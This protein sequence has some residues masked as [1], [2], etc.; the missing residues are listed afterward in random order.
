MTL[1]AASSHE[2]GMRRAA[3]LALVLGAVAIATVAAIA[4]GGGPIVAAAPVLAATTAYA[5]A[6]SPLRATVLP[7]LFV[8]LAVDDHRNAGGLWHT[9]WAPVGDLLRANLDSIIPAA[10]GLKLNGVEVVAIALLGLAAWRR[11]RADRIDQR[12][13]VPAAPVAFELA[14]LAVAAIV[15][16]TV[17]GL[18]RGGSLDTAIWQTRPILDTIAL[19]ALFA[20]ALRGPADH[21]AIGKM[22]VLAATMRALVATW[23][24]YAVA[25]TVPTHV[26]YTTDHG[27]SVLFALACAVLLTHLLE[28][29]DRRSLLHAA[30]FLPPILIGMHANAR[31]VAAVQ[32]AFVLAAVFLVGH[33]RT[34]RR[35]VARR[36][37]LAAPL[38]VLYAVAGWSSESRVFAPVH[39]VR[40]IVQNDADRSTWARHVESWNLAVSLRDR[41]LAG[42]GFGHEWDEVF[43]G[44]QIVSIFPQYR[45]APH[46]QI[47]GLL[48]FA[49]VAAF[50][51]IWG[52]LVLTVYLALR[53]YRLASA[54]ED[55]AAALCCAG[56]VL[57]VAV[58]FQGDLGAFWMQSRVVLAL[59]L[60]VAAKLAAA[61]GAWPT[62]GAAVAGEVRT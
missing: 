50:T 33:W 48:L 35:K 4:L 46:N 16:A 47:L 42:R 22:I 61:T 44:D 49:G 24:R 26:E 59:A 39:T 3:P 25:P 45:S 54:P 36:A 41:P 30:L 20:V 29:L 57:V 19:F 12:G 27:D 56:A 43:V 58:Q 51:A 13:V 14:A 40:S 9:P 21:V 8:V 1:A 23:V 52:L 7:F 10:R 62:R 15:L 28:R 32:L 38:V 53:A 6:R 5:V 37:L 11:A 17:H 55:R 18:A 34:W 60:A 31:R 2:R